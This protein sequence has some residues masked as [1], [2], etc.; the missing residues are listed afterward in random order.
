MFITCL[1]QAY[2]TLNLSKCEFVQATVPYVGKQVAHEQVRPVDDKVSA[3]L[4][5]S[6]HSTRHEMLISLVFSVLLVFA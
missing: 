1:E 6:T 3:I 4:N 2:L 5:I